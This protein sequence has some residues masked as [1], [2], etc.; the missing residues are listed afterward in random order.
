[1]KA[2]RVPRRINIHLWIKAGIF[3]ALGFII[4]G[5]TYSLYHNGE[6][7]AYVQQHSPLIKV[8][9]V[10]RR[11]G[12]GTV[13]V[14]NKILVS[15][16]GKT[17]CLSS[18]NRHFRQ[19]AR[20]DS[21]DINYDAE[22]DIAVLSVGQVGVPYPVMAMFLFAGLLIIGNVIYKLWEGGEGW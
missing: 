14:P 8:P 10:D 12:A 11:K 4:I 3:F 18:S 9:I 22:R 15:Y 2:N 19:I 21:I 5:F 13:K 1:M 17:Y 16:L 6:E 7:M 20:Q